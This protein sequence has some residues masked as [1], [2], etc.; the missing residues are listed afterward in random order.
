MFIYEIYPSKTFYQF[1]P[2]F[3]SCLFSKDLEERVG[4]TQ[5]PM[6]VFQK[7]CNLKHSL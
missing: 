3:T 2:T 6:D 5:H 4:N 7:F 1:L